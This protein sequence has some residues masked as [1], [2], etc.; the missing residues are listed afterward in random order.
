MRIFFVSDIH[1][2]F[3]EN[4]Q[5]IKH[6]SEK[7]YLQDALIFAGDAAHDLQTLQTMLLQLKSKFKE[8]FFVPGNHD[9]WIHNSDWADSLNKFEALIEWC[10]RHKIHTVPRS[11]GLK[12]KYPVR[13]VPLFSWYSGPEEGDDSLYLEKPG[14]DPENRMWSDNYYIRW[15]QTKEGFRASTYFTALNVEA[16][17]EKSLL[18]VIS[19]SHFLP[20]REMMFGDSLKP[21]PEKIRK[22]DRRPEF[23]FSRVAGSYLIEE[24]IREL[25][26][27]VH[28]YGHQHIN[29]DR[30]LDGVRYTAHCLGYPGERT[31][32][33]VKGIEQGLKQIWDTDS[34]MC[35]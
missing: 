20:R 17:K 23:N 8:F 31:R 33:M 19:F 7:K 28:I 26:S 2:D 12:D 30:V 25:N 15:P 27:V 16:L 9:L 6:I 22:Y 14:E 18:P 4:A 11:L 24:Q 35:P 10:T 3:T 29:R 21:N 34:G 32:G 5:W 1:I 13:I